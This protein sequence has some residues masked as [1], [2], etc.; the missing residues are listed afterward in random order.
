MNKTLEIEL[1]AIEAEQLES[2]ASSHGYTDPADY[3]KALII[4]EAALEADDDPD[5]GDLAENFR[6]AWL[7]VKQ[8]NTLSEEEFWK[9]VAN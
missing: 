4:A 7:E 1:S 8:G 2:L 3:I 6:Q 9:A 5:L